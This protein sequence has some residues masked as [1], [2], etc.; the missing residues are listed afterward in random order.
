[1]VPIIERIPGMSDAELVNL[2]DNAERL[3]ESGSPKQVAAA[4]EVL[5]A[6]VTELALRKERQKAALALAR[7]DSRAERKR[8]AADSAT[9]G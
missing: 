3:A 6:V 2:R 8:A 7:A 9:A 4:S 1:M 5:P